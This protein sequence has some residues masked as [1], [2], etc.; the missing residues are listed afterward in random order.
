MLYPI[1]LQL[2]TLLLL[3]KIEAYIV[4]AFCCTVVHTGTVRRLLLGVGYAAYYTCVS[5][6]IYAALY[7]TQSFLRLR[8][9][10]YTRVSDAYTYYQAI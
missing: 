4:R 3:R 6:Y 5:A 1:A 7:D 9:I 2:H 8:T 10:R